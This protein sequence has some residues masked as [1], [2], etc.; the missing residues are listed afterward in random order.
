MKIKTSLLISCAIW[1]S[2]AA[3]LHAAATEDEAKRLTKVFQSYL[4]DT[5][6]VVSVALDGDGYSVKLDFGPL[7]DIA[8][9]MSKDKTGV[10]KMSPVEFKIASQGDGKWQVVENQP[11]TFDR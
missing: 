2:A 8:A 4:S 7:A 3:Q 6:G 10:I 11:F 9:A 5:Q 1:I